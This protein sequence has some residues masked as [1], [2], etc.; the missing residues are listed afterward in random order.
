MQSCLLAG[1]ATLA[2]PASAQVGAPPV[3]RQ[4]GPAANVGEPLAEDIVVTGFRSSLARALDA[5]RRAT[6]FQDSILAEE[7]GKFP[8][9]NLA[10]SLQRIP[11]VQI[12]R[13][14]GEGTR[15]SLRGLGPDY[16][17]TTLNGLPMMPQIATDGVGGRGVDFDLFPSELFSR[18]TVDKTAR[19]SLIEGGLSGTVD[20]SI[21]H[22]FDRPGFHVNAAA[23]GQYSE[24]A[25]RITPKGSL[26]ISNTW[27]EKFGALVG[28]AYSRRDVFDSIYETLNFTRPRVDANGNGAIDNSERVRTGFQFNPI[29]PA[30]TAGVSAQALSQGY[31]ARLPRPAMYLGSRERLGVI[32]SVQFRPTE[33]VS[34]DLDLTYVRLSNDTDFHNS[35]LAVRNSTQMRP[36]GVAIDAN[37]TAT[38]ATFTNP[39]FLNISGFDDTKTRFYQSVL[40]GRWEISDDLLVDA[41]LGYGKSISRRRFG[42]FL[43]DYAVPNSS[44]V[45]YA[46]PD[47]HDALPVVTPSFDITQPNGF[48]LIS[49]RNQP[50]YR[51]TE[52]VS[53][54][55]SARLGDD[56]T[57]LRVGVD[58][59]RENRQRQYIQYNNPATFYAS[60]FTQAE[61]S[62]LTEASPSRYFFNVDDRIGYRRFVAGNLPAL[63]RRFNFDAMQAAALATDTG[64]TISRESNLGIYAEANGILD[65]AGNDL[66]LNAGVRGV[67]TDQYVRYIFNKAPITSDRSYFELLP[68]LNAAYNVGKDLTLRFAAARTM[69]RPNPNQIEPVTGVSLAGDVSTGNPMLRP[70]FSNQVDLGAEWYY[71]PGAALTVAFF[72][73]GIDNFVAPSNFQAPFSQ[74]GVDLT[75]LDSQILKALTSGGNTIVN[76]STQQNIG[77]RQTLKGIEA[78]FQQPLSMLIAGLGFIG[79]VTYADANAKS[80]IQGLSRYA[81]NVTGYYEK[82]AVNLRL[83]YNYR[84]KYNVCAGPC[85]DLLPDPIVVRGKGQMDLSS[86]VKLPFA[87]DLALTFEALN[88]TDADERSY[89]GVANRLVGYRKP[90]RQVFFGVRGSF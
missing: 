90:G 6:T 72:Y 37:N 75:T 84:S 22:P 13:T 89:M 25:D 87:Q 11:G 51:Y 30:T 62:A 47:T 17:R 40:R 8:D 27:G 18:I 48:N 45:S 69:T 49:V 43:F 35:A 26:I 79:N 23:Q 58:Y 52:N 46:I 19:A 56:Q 21:A 57:N 10:E 65:I 31:F 78:G 83:S 61:V 53:A 9:N 33:R 74:S 16:T 1:A 5:K 44:T 70:Y 63:D 7:I 66:R 88:L 39:D 20:L 29:A 55:W 64:P 86:S 54:H 77:E 14:N 3:D 2:V 12:E 50:S 59:D 4:A 68:S 34:L 80:Q 38:A 82:G 41:S 85:Q 28:F 76:Y 60:T 73:K 24:Q 67:N 36:S 32:G 15:I 81:Y 71:A 42:S